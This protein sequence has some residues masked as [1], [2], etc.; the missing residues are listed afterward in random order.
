MRAP[1]TE[2]SLH[3]VAGPAATDLTEQVDQ[4]TPEP[5]PENS[6]LPLPTP[7]RHDQIQ[8][9]YYLVADRSSQ[10]ATIY[11]RGPDGKYSVIEKQFAVA[12]SDTLPEGIYRAGEKTRWASMRGGWARY[13]V[14]IGNTFI[15]SCFYDEADNGTLIA[16]SYNN[17]GLKATGEGITCSVRDAMSVYDRADS[18]TVEVVSSGTGVAM[19][20]NLRPEQ[21]P[22]NAAMDPTD[23]Q[24]NGYMP[25][26]TEA[27]APVTTDAPTEEPK[28]P[29]GAIPYIPTDAPEPSLT[30]PPTEEITAEPDYETI[31]P[32]F[33]DPPSVTE[34]E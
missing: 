15:H 9:N 14:T 19:T 13:A 21:I 2:A 23:P 6:W 10:A 11:M 1:P 25:S 32:F 29:T 26:R 34:N 33:Y 5:W 30:P 3:R 24:Y 4:S 27:G 8:T 20:V 17:L 7:S 18:L 12:V 28:Q 22:Q 31:P 16:A